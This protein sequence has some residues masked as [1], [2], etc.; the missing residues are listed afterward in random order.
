M[1]PAEQ[2][3]RVSAFETYERGLNALIGGSL[4]LPWSRPRLANVVK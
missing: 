2:I 3:C 4:E 1:A